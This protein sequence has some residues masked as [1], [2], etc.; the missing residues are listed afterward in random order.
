MIIDLTHPLTPEIPSWD[1][2]CGF[3]LST[4]TDFQDCSGPDRFR[5]Q[6]FSSRAGLGTHIDAP[7]HCF[8]GATTVDELPLENLVTNC[9]VIRPGDIADHTYMVMPDAIQAF[10]LEHGT[11]PPNSFVIV[12]TGWSKYW[13]EPEKY[14]NKLRFPSVHE[15]TAQLLLERKIA[16]LGT[17]TLSADSR[18]QSFPV[19]RAILGAGKYLVENIANAEVLPAVGAKSFIL[20]IKIKDGTEAPVRLVAL[21]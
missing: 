20:P 17:D 19:H 3:R 13:S 16:G 21:I 2:G 12:H 8:P 1:G 6:E 4:I 7:A 14:R 9:V 18:G 11:I 5:V 15:S 10:E